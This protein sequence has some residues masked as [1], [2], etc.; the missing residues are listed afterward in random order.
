[1]QAPHSPSATSQDGFTIIETMVACVLLL[2]GMAATVVVITQAASTTVKTRTREQATN[3]QRELVEAARS[4]SYDQLTPNGM[5]AAVRARPALGDSALGA[6]GWTIRRRDAT[7]TVSMSV[8][9]VDD[10]RDG[11]GAHEAGV[12]CAASGTPPTAAECQ[13]LI[14]MTAAGTLPGGNVLAGLTVPQLNQLGQCGIDANLDGTV[15]GLV[16][17][18]ATVCLLGSC[19]TPADTNP[20]DYKRVV[21]LVRWPGGSNLQTSQINSPGQAAAPAVTSLT[22]VANTITNASTTSL[23]LTATA[24]NDPE[25]VAL[26]QDGTAITPAFTKGATNWTSTWNLGSVTAAGGQPAATEIVDGSYQLSAKAFNKYGQYGATRA[27]TIV[28]NRRVAFA[29]A[30][31]GAG[32]NGAQHVEIAWSP[33]RERDSAGFRVDRRTNTLSVLGAVT[34]GAWT[35][36]CARAVRTTCRDTGAPAAA[37]LQVVEYSVVGYDLDSGGAVRAGERSAVQAVDPE[38]ERPGT[39]GSLQ[40][41]LDEGNVVLTWTAPAGTTPDHYNVYRGGQSFDDRLDSVYITPGQSLT[42]TDTATSGQS[43]DYWITAVN[44]QLGESAKLGPVNR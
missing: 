44:S 17:A 36:V 13:N 2:V 28:V 42:Y 8:C 1:M 11:T 39:P 6:A 31:V 25:A 5:G 43:H 7:Y 4:V 20:A 40:A 9:T 21:S 14:D 26:Y 35:E 3:L 23:G 41:S 10:P 29:P 16:S 37:L 12:F 27:Q 18:T 38:Q 22:A 19:S 15:D 24:T 32:R 33:A 34:A 30:H